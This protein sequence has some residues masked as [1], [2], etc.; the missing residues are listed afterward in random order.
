MFIY[1][2]CISVFNYSDVYIYVYDNFQ[3][4]VYTSHGMGV[5][6]YFK[7]VKWISFV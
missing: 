1:K 2:P 7:N 4:V 3:R 6:L 5:V